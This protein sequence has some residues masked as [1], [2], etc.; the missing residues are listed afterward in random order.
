MNTSWLDMKT[1]SGRQM[2]VSSVFYFLILIFA[3]TWVVVIELLVA[4]VLAYFTFTVISEEDED[5][6]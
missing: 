2:I 4:L 1:W 3:P 6:S 5:G